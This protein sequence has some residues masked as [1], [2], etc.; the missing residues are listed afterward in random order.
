[1]HI[2]RDRESGEG[3]GIDLDIQE[4]CVHNMYAQGCGRRFQSWG[5]GIVIGCCAEVRGLLGAS[6][7]S[8]TVLA[9]TWNSKMPTR[10][11]QYPKPESSARIGYRVHH[12]FGYFGGPDTRLHMASLVQ[13]GGI[14]FRPPGELEQLELQGTVYLETPNVSLVWVVFYIPIRK[15]VI[16]KKEVH[17]SLRVERRRLGKVT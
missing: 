4:Q 11:A 8:L 12:S 1:M 3:I 14:A 15:K 9:A 6:W 2:D 7:G 16:T 5:W 17:E 10:M 13:N